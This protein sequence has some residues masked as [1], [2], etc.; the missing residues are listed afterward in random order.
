VSYL[1]TKKSIYFEASTDAS[2]KYGIRD[3]R[4]DRVKS[5]FL[6]TNFISS[7]L[8][9]GYTLYWLAVTCI[10]SV[11]RGV[12]VVL[13]S[14]FYLYALTA[15]VSVVF[16][17]TGVDFFLVTL[18]RCVELLIPW[19]L[20]VPGLYVFAGVAVTFT[21]IVFSYEL[22]R[23]P[24]LL[25]NLYSMPVCFLNLAVFPVVAAIN[26]LLFTKD[27]V[28]CSA[29]YLMDCFDTR[30]AH[31]CLTEYLNKNPKIKNIKL[32]LEQEED[33]DVKQLRKVVD[34]IP[35]SV[36]KII[37]EMPVQ[38]YS[39]AT[40]N[41]LFKALNS[42]NREKIFFN[43]QELIDTWKTW[44]NTHTFRTLEQTSQPGRPRLSQDVI[45]YGIFSYIEPSGIEKMFDVLSPQV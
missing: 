10:Y 1:N 17:D 32:Y 5:S 28:F 12:V 13:S 34:A 14:L 4:Y 29:Y 7:V 43:T 30:P 26:I 45:K 8:D 44:Q 18:N 38:P 23:S 19:L 22:G 20:S 15:F 31:E 33:L 24:E 27:A 2:I 41:N 6:E 11:Y 21:A 35:S 9:I 40:K 25:H 3:H 42:V 37:F 16:L 36:K 39:E